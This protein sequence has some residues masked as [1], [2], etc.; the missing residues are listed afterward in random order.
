MEPRPPRGEAARHVQ[1]RAD[2]VRR[3]TDPHSR[4]G[5]ARKQIRLAV[6]D[7]DRLSAL[8]EL[9]DDVLENLEE[10][11]RLLEE[12]QTDLVGEEEDDALTGR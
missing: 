7:L 5:E 1:A 9:D 11:D 2:G 12:I 8:E 4:L 3:M 6:E 10:A